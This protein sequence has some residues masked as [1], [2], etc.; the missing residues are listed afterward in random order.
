[1][2]LTTNC[3]PT[4]GS[5]PNLL[6]QPVLHG[7]NPHHRD[8]HPTALLQGRVCQQP[9][10]QCEGFSCLGLIWTCNNGFAPRLAAETGVNDTQRAWGRRGGQGETETQRRGGIIRPNRR[11]VHLS[12]K[13]KG[14]PPYLNHLVTGGKAT[15]TMQLGLVALAIIFISSMGH[16]DDLKLSKARRQRRGES[17]PSLRTFVFVFLVLHRAAAFLLLWSESQRRTSC[18]H[19]TC[20]VKITL[21]LFC[22]SSFMFFRA[23]V[24]LVFFGVLHEIILLSVYVKL[25]GY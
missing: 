10:C 19:Q 22:N 5:L 3:P 20:K 11:E 25:Y 1:M 6:V 12:H 14:S 15:G 17:S 7:L 16:S 21:C 2:V 9:R 23:W 8:L 24:V 13:G 18:K 4:T